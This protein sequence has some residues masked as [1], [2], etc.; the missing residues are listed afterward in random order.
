[1]RKYN[2]K[3]MIQPPLPGIGPKSEWTPTPVG[4]LPSW[5]GVK[6]IGLDLETCD[7]T[8][9][10]Y[11]PGVRRDGWV[12]GI[13]FAFEDGPGFYLPIKHSDDNLQAH[14]V[15]DYLKEQAATY[16]GIIVGANL[17]YDLDY[18]AENG[19]WFSKVKWF[20]DVQI[21]EPLIDELKDSYS[22]QSISE[23]YDLPG[24]D[25][26]L[27]REAAALWGIDAKKEMYKLPARFVAPYAIWDAELPL[28]LL[29][30]QERII[31]EQELWDIY[32]LESRLLPALLKMRR[33]GVAVDFKH[34]DKVQDFG[35]AETKKALEVVYAE[36]RVRINWDD[37]FKAKA[38]A[39][40]LE[41]I[42]VV[43]KTTKNG[44]PQIDKDLLEKLD[45]PVATAL[46]RARK[47]NKL[48]TT[49]VQ[50]VRNHETNGRIHCSFNQLRM[51]K[52][53]EKGDSKGGRFGRLSS[54][55]PNMQQ[56][57]ARD[58]ELGPFWRK[59]FIPDSG[60]LWG[61][62]D[63]SQQEPRWLIDFAERCNLPR[64]KEAADKYRN[65]PATDN[66]QMIADM[67]RIE[68]KPA[69]EI[70]LGKCYGMGPSKMCHKLGLPTKWIHSNRMNRM[71]EVAGPEGDAII[72][73]F[74]REL[75]FV[76]MLAKLCEEKAKERGFILTVLGRRCR[77][78][79]NMDEDSKDRFDWCHKALNRLIQGSSADQTKQAVVL[80]DEMG[81][82]LQLQ[83]HDEVTASVRDRAHGEEIGEV[84]T[85]CVPSNVPFKVDVEVG[86]S[87]GSAA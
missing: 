82:E 78:P 23:Q 64:A 77:F 54:S 52:D 76:K 8:L 4:Q 13:S 19:V 57:L 20:R 38:L 18:L 40:A 67:C 12:C 46:G 41:Y 56:Q 17:Q 61:S 44:L 16:E 42:G 10:K 59:V 28:R 21:A 45:H 5:A 55:N 31:E 32:N 81:E 51:T 29:R 6:R 53:D 79:E 34:L 63:Y 2:P 68:R 26:S 24:K 84:M 73:Q 9:K 85:N 33:R 66:H 47:T 71:I 87:W 65:D 22:L 80:L 14:H 7:P 83:V 30:R 58:P 25:E 37:V 1:M 69:K 72:K 39:P 62:M 74:D 36:T 15:W 43:L 75:P 3:A 50:S 48:V 11:G 27:L 49:F 35:I 86:T 70:L 60:R